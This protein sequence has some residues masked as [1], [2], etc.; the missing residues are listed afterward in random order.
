MI[1]ERAVVRPAYAIIPGA[2]IKEN[3]RS[4]IPGWKGT[5]AWVLAAPGIGHA[6]G[7]AQYLVYLDP[8]GGCAR[9]EVQ[10]EVEGFVYVLEGEVSL[11]LEG[12]TERLGP[13]RFAFIPAGTA[14]EVF[15]AQAEEARFIWLRKRFE[16]LGDAKPAP[17]VGDERD[18]PRHTMPTSDAVSATCLIPTDDIAYDMHMNVVEFGPGTCISAVE[19]HV[20]EHG[21]YMLQGKGMYL[22]NETWHEVRA[23]DFIWMRAFC[24]QAYYAGGPGPTRYLLYK[25]V[26]RQIAL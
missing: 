2:A 10:A 11:S 17:I 26:N 24:P 13:G 3:V 23:G 25:N 19:A 18:L 8:E 5:R 16:P 9:P 14:W 7:F 15:N 22:L 12:R 20:M 6:V 21:L 1:T 4:I